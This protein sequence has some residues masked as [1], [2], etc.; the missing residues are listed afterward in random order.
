METVSRNPS[1]HNTE[2]VV[3]PLSSETSDQVLFDSDFVARLLG[4]KHGK[5]LSRSTKKRLRRLRGDIIDCIEPQ[6]KSEVYSI[7]ET[8]QG[9]II[10]TCGHRFESRKMAHTLKGASQ[11]VCFIATVGASID[12]YI[13][14]L[15]QKGKMA[16][17]YIADALGSGA[18]EHVAEKFHN[19][20]RG[21]IHPE[22]SVSLRFS[23]GYCDWQ[24]TE[25]QKIFSLIDGESIGVSL[26]PTSLMAPRKSISAVFGIFPRAGTFDPANHNP[27]F[28]CAKKDCIARRPESF[29]LYH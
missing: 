22:Q 16:D 27:C 13:D 19:G 7:Q 11:L 5:T 28:H 12:S 10:L 21:N 29:P 4:R 9:R 14:Q 6:I 18:I 26:Q 24:I 17:A 20:F 25:Q 3:A 23:P 8:K 1:P 15:M 2:Q